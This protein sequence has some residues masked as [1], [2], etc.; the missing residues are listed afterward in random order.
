MVS[1][2]PDFHEMLIDLEVWDLKH[3]NRIINQI[4]SKRVVSTVT[5]VN[6]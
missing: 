6:G 1:R 3:L 5:R 4:R 2:A